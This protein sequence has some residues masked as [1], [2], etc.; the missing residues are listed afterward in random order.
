[1]RPHINA[2][3][4]GH[5]DS[6]KTTATVHLIY[7]CG[8]IDHR[9]IANL[10]R[11][12]WEFGDIKAKY[13]WV[14]D[15]SRESRFRGLTIFPSLIN[16]ETSKFSFTMI[17]TPGHGYFRKTMIAATSQADIAILIVPASCG[18]FEAAFAPEGQLKKQ[19]LIAFALGIRQLIVCVNKLDST[20]CNYSQQRYEEIKDEVMRFLYRIG[21]TEENLRILP[22]SGW[23]GDNLIEFSMKMRWYTGPTLLETLENV[24]CPTRDENKPLRISIRNVYKKIG[25]GCVPV[26]KIETGVLRQGMVVK[27]VPSGVVAEVQSI[28]MHHSPLEVAKAGDYV[29]FSV[30]NV[31]REDVGRGSVVFDCENDPAAVCISFVAELT[32]TKHIGEIKKGYS[33]VIHCH[34]AYATCRFSR[35]LQKVDKKTGEVVEDEDIRLK[36]GD[37]ALVELTPLTPICVE[38]FEKYPA[39]GRII[40]RDMREI[41]AIGI[42]KTVIR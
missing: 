10:E 26:G 2:A 32:I 5:V 37:L 25:V 8:G 22:I 16:L 18:E 12:T 30:G 28:E 40:V 31:N 11:V 35:I 42:V 19:A 17:D 15:R 39:L 34:T 14:L 13:S 21:F 9:T 4:I 20:T 23:C 41:V 29:G 24:V 7:K 27:F 6:G 33:P 1:M 36:T 3:V 38:E